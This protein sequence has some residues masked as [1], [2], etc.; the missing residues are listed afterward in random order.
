[1]FSFCSAWGV[2]KVEVENM[3]GAEK[4]DEFFKAFC[5][6]EACI[7]GR[8]PISNKVYTIRPDI[9]KEYSQKYR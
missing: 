5:A 1:M 6:Y 2:W 7:L 3:R 4:G 8:K 9:I